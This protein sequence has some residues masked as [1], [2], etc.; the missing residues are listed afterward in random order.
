[1]P[2]DINKYVIEKQTNKIDYNNNPFL[3]KGRLGQ[4][5]F[6]LYSALI[7]VINKYIISENFTS[8]DLCL[9]LVSMVMMLFTYRNRL[10]DI[11]LKNI[12]SWGFASLLVV[13]LIILSSFSGY[14]YTLLAPFHLWILF[15]PS[16]VDKEERQEETEIKE[17]TQEKILIKEKRKMSQGWKRILLSIGYTIFCILGMFVGGAC[18]SNSDNGLFNLIAI[19]IGFIAGFKL[20]EFIIKG[21]NW[22]KEGFKSDNN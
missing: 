11:T 18:S 5:Y 1:M 17:T 6:F 19:I 10:Y 14:W 20:F 16:K 21:I 22:I 2:L 12:K 9:F 4:A 3:P 7:N 8:S 13:L 15:T